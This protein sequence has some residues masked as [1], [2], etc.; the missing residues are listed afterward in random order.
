M[1]IELPKHYFYGPEKNGCA[2]V[3]DGILVVQGHINY[4]ELMYNLAYVL[5]GY[6]TCAFCGKNLEQ[7][8]RTLDHLYPR[9]WGGVSIPHN[10][11][12]ACSRCNSLKGNLTYEQFMKFLELKVEDREEYRRTCIEENSKTMQNKSFILPEEWVSYFNTALILPGIDLDWIEESGNQTIDCYY[13]QNGHYP[14]PII[15]SANN[16]VF[17]GFHILYHA[18]MHG[19]KKVPAII[20]ENVIRIRNPKHE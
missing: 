6:E 9:N 4:E 17:K 16:W 15:I 7:R 2:Y 3:R 20:L 5:K 10:L 14:K 13:K 8:T 12:P 1:I 18:K 11:M 19:I